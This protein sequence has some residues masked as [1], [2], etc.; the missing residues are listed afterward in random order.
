MEK[1]FLVIMGFSS[2]TVVSAGIIAF[3][4][5][6]GIVPRMAERTQTKQY[7]RFYEDTIL[8]GGIF[9]VAITLFE[10]QLNFHPIVVGI[11]A[12]AVGS[13]MGILAV[14]LAEVL[15]VMP[16]LMRRTRIIK[17]LPWLL[18]ALTLGKV[19]GSFMYFYIEGFFEK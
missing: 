6:M 4:T 14:A 1:V 13:F 12:F 7:I 19:I 2:G 18:F 10:V 5:A 3:I 11:Y 15:N 17:G 8:L 16:I 9:A